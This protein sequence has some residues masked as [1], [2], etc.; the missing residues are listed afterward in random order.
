MATEH[1]E[2]ERPA[3]APQRST[4]TA[5]E[6]YELPDDDYQYELVSGELVRMSPSGAEHGL[7]T[8]ALS[9]ALRE[10]VNRTQAGVCCGAETGFILQRDPDVVRAPDAAFVAWERIPASGVPKSYWPFAPDLAAEVISPGD[11]FADLQTKVVEYFRAGTRLV[12]VIEPA[13]RTVYVYRARRDVQALGEQ[14]DLTGGEALPG[15]RCPVRE[16]FTRRRP[17]DPAPPVN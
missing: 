15:F 5:E 12:W 4:L 9:H 1:L 11:R 10:Y 13:T 3:A 17:R 8:A 14:D 7:V 16:L 6:L 2:T